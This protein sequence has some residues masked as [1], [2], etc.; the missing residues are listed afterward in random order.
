MIELSHVALPIFAT[1]LPTTEPTWND[2]AHAFYAIL[3]AECPNWQ[4]GCTLVPNDGTEE[5]SIA[6]FEANIAHIIKQGLKIRVA[7]TM[8]YWY[9]NTQTSRSIHGEHTLI[10]FCYVAQSHDEFHGYATEYFPKNYSQDA[11]W[12]F[13]ERIIRGDTTK[14][15]QLSYDIPTCMTL[16]QFG[17]M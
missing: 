13:Q 3:G 16:N 10:E 8:S 17:D 4:D 6:Q 1:L 5:S 2:R 7:H 9:I 15:T 11:L 14:A 12:A